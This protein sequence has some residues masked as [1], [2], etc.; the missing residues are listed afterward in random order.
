MEWAELKEKNLC[1]VC[2][3]D[4]PLENVDVCSRECAVAFGER[5]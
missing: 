4:M 2:K 5:E 1:R 3:K